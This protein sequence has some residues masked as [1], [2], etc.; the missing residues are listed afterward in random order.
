MHNS[1]AVNRN[2][3]D[4]LWSESQLTRPDRFN[5]WSLIS[6]LLTFAPARLEIG[7]GL[8][9]R[10]PVS[11]TCFID[12]SPPAIEQLKTNG[13]IALFADI[14]ALPFS[15]ETF[16]LVCAF[17]VIEHVEHDRRVF[18]EV[19]RVL[20]EGGRFVFSVPVHAALWTDFDEFVGHVRR[21]DPADLTALLAAHDLVIDKSAAYGMQPA[22]PRLLDFGLRCL[23]HS[24][25]EAMWLY[26][27][28]LMPLGMLFQKRLKFV[29]GL[30]DATGVDEIV[31]VCRKRTATAPVQ[32]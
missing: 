20:K 27:K 9:P 2:F 7:P 19:S 29:A 23:K 14:A 24:R 17:D 12:I 25:R 32:C 21:Y 18:S 28:V 5:T 16:E 26:N 22:N 10:L 1:N 13:G 8:R 11:G 6:G 31:L 4:I 30:I 15:D 3:Y